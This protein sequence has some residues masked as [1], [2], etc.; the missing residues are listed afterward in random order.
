MAAGPRGRAESETLRR[1][2]S[3]M[4]EN[5][6]GSSPGGGLAL[7]QR[8]SDARSVVAERARE[9]RGRAEAMRRGEGFRDKY[10]KTILPFKT[11]VL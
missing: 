8:P 4:H 6:Q 11:L 9:A 5:P 10:Q 3:S 7:S 1:R 2:G